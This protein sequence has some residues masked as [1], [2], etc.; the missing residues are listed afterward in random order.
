MKLNKVNSV[1]FKG[2]RTKYFGPSNT[3]APYIKAYAHGGLSVKVPIKDELSIDDNH[4]LAARALQDKYQW[5]GQHLVQGS[6]D[7]G[8]GYFFVQV[9]KACLA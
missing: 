3:K 6:S 8:Q 9:P 1:I 5:D 7:D 4:L 2:I